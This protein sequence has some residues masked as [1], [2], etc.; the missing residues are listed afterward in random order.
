MV[1]AILEVTGEVIE[2]V[3]PIF[4]ADPMTAAMTALE[5]N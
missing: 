5:M 4:Y 3:D 2:R 1:V